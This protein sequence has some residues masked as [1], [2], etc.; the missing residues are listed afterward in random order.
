MALVLG[1]AAAETA[2]LVRSFASTRAVVMVAA[3]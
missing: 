1:A 2:V 3:V